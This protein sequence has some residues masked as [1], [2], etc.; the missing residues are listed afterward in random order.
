MGK[1]EL[2]EETIDAAGIAVRGIDAGRRVG[3]ARAFDAIRRADSAEHDVNM[4]RSDNRILCS[5]AAR[6][7]GALEVTCT[8]NR[9]DELFRGDNHELAGYFPQ[10][11]LNNGRDAM[12]RLINDRHDELTRIRAQIDEAKA[13]RKDILAGT[14]EVREKAFQAA[15]RKDRQALM[16]E[17]EIPNQEELLWWLGRYRTSAKRVKR[18]VVE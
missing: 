5:F 9:I 15:R 7:Y 11:P 3:W 10:G 4:L 12:R 18:P 17:F 1:V 8:R 16:E 2:E 14:Y 6:A 13:E